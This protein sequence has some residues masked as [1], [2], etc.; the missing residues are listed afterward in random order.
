MGR[1]GCPQ[2]SSASP[3]AQTP[4]KAE[5]MIRLLTP[6]HPWYWQPPQTH[7]FQCFSFHDCSLASFAPVIPLVNPPAAAMEAWGAP[8][9][10]NP[11]AR[12][13]EA[14]PI[15]RRALGATGEP[16]GR[17]ARALA[18]PK[19]PSRNPEVN[20]ANLLTQGVLINSQSITWSLPEET[21]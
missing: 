16:G 15:A 21:I 3:R 5:L 19:L 7:H 20:V 17:G 18:Q 2:F 14:A 11:L 1:S 6:N 8:T 9:G 13:P 4:A 12:S 10:C